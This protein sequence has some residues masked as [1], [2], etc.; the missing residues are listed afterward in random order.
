MITR[1][2]IM[3]SS[4]FTLLEVLVSMAVL[5][6]GLL[7]LAGMEMFGNR[8]IHDSY[9][10]TQAVILAYDI[11]DRMRANMPGVNDPAMAA[12]PKRKGNYDNVTNNLTP[13]DSCESAASACT[14]SQLAAYDIYQWSLEI[15]DSL[16][17]GTATLK[18]VAEN[19]E[20]FTL[21]ISWTT[22]KVDKKTDSGASD[23]ETSQFTLWF[24]P[25]GRNQ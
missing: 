18:R 4:G 13:A 1:S 23:T 12:W 8:Y 20:F 14:A 17:Q 7:G 19:S 10:R 22:R 15:K 3:K 9:L 25:W 16:P 2:F 21:T 11:I 5:S 24:R 6:V